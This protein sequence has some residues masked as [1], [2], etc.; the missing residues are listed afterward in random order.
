M[1][2]GQSDQHATGHYDAARAEVIDEP[3]FQRHEPGLAKHEDS[4]RDLDGGRPQPYLRLMGSTNS[5]QP[6]CRFAIITMQTTPANS[7]SQRP[8]GS[9]GVSEGEKSW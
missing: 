4:E 2:P 5:V 7:C 1:H 8:V 3:A 6:Y 9:I